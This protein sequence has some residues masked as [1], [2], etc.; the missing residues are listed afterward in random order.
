MNSFVAIDVETANEDLSSICQIGMVKYVDGKAVDQFESLINP[1]S[2][3]SRINI[4]IHGIEKEQ[5]TNSPTFEELWPRVLGFF[6][7]EV[8]V[9]HTHFDRAAISQAASKF[10]CLP[11]L[12][13]NWLDSAKVAR[14]AWA[15]FTNAG[16]GLANVAE[17]LGIEF[18]HHDALE[19]AK[20]CGQILVKACLENQMDVAQW[21]ERCGRPINLE[22]S[23]PITRE[24]NEEGNYFGM[25]I[26]FTGALSL[27][28][29][30][31]ADLAAS[32]GFEVIQGVTKKLDILV[33]GDQ[34]ISKLNNHSK[35]AKHRKAEKLI[36]EGKGLRIIQESDFL[37]ICDHP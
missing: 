13:N 2:D 8:L 30:D 20:A 24:G 22:S 26:A 21:M 33:V 7:D 35:S 19:D 27:P 32:A 36:E 11:K 9:S 34:D 3:F 5:T 29:R 18:Q 17:H 6:Q 10:N 37:A 25:T 1:L 12:S 31:A 28:R 4:S 23:G 15:D 14:R 16:Y